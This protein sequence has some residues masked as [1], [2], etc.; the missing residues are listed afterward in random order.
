MKTTILFAFTLALTTGGVLGQTNEIAGAG[1]P[2]V[3]L[4]VSDY[5]VSE[6]GPHHRVWQRE[7]YETL[8]DGGI[9]TNLNSY[10]ELASGLNYRDASGNWVASQPTIEIYSGGAVAQRGQH[11]VIFANNLNTV[12]AIDA[13]MPDGMRLRSTVLG[14]LYSDAT[15]GQSVQIASLQSSEGELVSDDEVLYPSAL[16]DPDTGLA[17]DVLYK[18]RVDGM[19]QNIVLETQLPDP[20][21]YGMDPA[22]TY[23]GV[24]TE[25]FS[26]PTATVTNL[27]A[28]SEAGPDQAISWGT[29]I[30]GRG[31]AF[32]LGSGTNS[33]PVVKRYDQSGGRYFLLEKVRYEDVQPAVS[34]LPGHASNM[35]PAQ[36]LASREFKYPS[37]PVMKTA[38]RPIGKAPGKG[39]VLDYTSMSTA[40]TNYCFQGSAEYFVSGPLTLAGTNVFE[41]GVVIKMATNGSI[42]GVTGS[43]FNFVSGPYRPVVFSSKDDNTLSSSISGSTGTPSG[44]YG[45]P[46]L[47]LGSMSGVSLSDFRICYAKRG[48]SASGGAVVIADGQF[49]NC[50]TAISDIYTAVTLKNVLLSNVKTNFNV[51]DSFNSISVQNGTFNNAFELVNGI[52]GATG[53]YL[54]NCAFVNV[55]NISGGPRGGYNGFYRSPSFGSS[56]VTTTYNP[57]QVA[58]SANCYLTNGCAFLNAGTTNIDSAALALVQANTVYAP[59]VFSNVTI[60]IPTN[61]WPQAQRDNI[62][63]PSL[64]YHY[65]PLDW[66]FGAVVAK[67]N[68]VF[69]A[70]TA[71]GFFYN[72][73]G[74]TY[75]LAVSDGAAAIFNGTATAPCR[76]ARQWTV[77]EGGNGKWTSTSY[78]GGITGTSFTRTAPALLGQFTGFYELAT[79]GNLFRDNYVLLVMGLQNCEIYC[80]GYGGYAASVNL[81]N[82]LSFD[83][84]PG[85]FWNYG[86]NNLNLQNCTCYRGQ[87]EGDNTTSGS[88]PVNIV[89]CAFDSTTFALTSSSNTNGYH[90]DYNSFIVNSNTTPYF[91]GHEVYVTNYNWQ[92]SWFGQFYLPTNS[93][94]INTGS[95]TANLL[96]LYQY[97]T[98]TN[99]VKE[100]NTIVDIGR[101]YVATDVYG[102]PIVTDGSGIPDYL[103]DSNGNGVFDT[104]DLA[105]WL[106]SPFNN[107]SGTSVLSVFTPLK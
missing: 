84:S 23:L 96:G 63:S 62:G 4:S 82:C 18:N 91:G 65:Y 54:T 1:N 95:T 69:S 78:L 60:T 107:L 75:G 103:A 6:V 36:G 101:H 20:Q 83:C 19:E 47:N 35:K 48:I 70:G 98:Q 59:V 100:T 39:F 32:A 12:G 68:I 14:L 79:E 5:Q 17:A 42:T 40:Y 26:P 41:G 88:W 44:Y 9:H 25:F 28:D 99:Q 13:Q 102:N 31:K 66:V 71:A 52:W 56:A 43:K 55:T 73:S 87:V 3:A 72:S 104:G 97:T 11:K 30:L 51:V 67:S 106:I 37:A 8:P 76:W 15:S 21:L 93:P 86:S 16:V 80:G 22:T 46:V 24:F 57:L 92:T 90:T 10:Y 27:P 2:P 89:N 49:V 81:T 34:G 58:G 45:D 29:T 53:I 38:A 50:G 64:G 94:L 85:I 33:V 74:A 61:L 7:S 77:Q 105:N